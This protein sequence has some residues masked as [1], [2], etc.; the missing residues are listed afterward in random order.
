MRCDDFDL[1]GLVYLVTSISLGTYCFS[2]SSSL[3]IPDPLV[4]RFDNNMTFL[5]EIP[6]TLTLRNVYLWFFISVP[7][8][9]NRKNF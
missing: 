6:S 8:C 4:E 1:E 2:T 3:G 5:A 9:C 7:I